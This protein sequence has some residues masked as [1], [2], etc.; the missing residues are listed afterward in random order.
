MSSAKG[1]VDS[2]GKEVSKNAVGLT[3]AVQSGRAEEKQLTL[4]QFV[5]FS[6]ES[7]PGS[8]LTDWLKVRLAHLTLEKEQRDLEF[9]LHKELE[10]KKMEAETE[11]KLWQ[12][13]LQASLVHTVA[14]LRLNPCI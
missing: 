6:V 10:I 14:R 4:P 9:Q 7:T 8:K 2:E 1:R 5:T 13:E 11:I 3:P 12:L